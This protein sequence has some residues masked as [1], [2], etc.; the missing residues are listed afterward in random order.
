MP[1][2][3]TKKGILVPPDSSMPHQAQHRYPRVPLESK[4][5]PWG[6]EQTCTTGLSYYHLVLAVA[7]VPASG[8]GGPPIRGAWPNPGAVLLEALR[9]N[10][11]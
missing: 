1:Q 6:M 8:Q 9:D 7:A 11:K 3:K 2:K 10:T 5:G 4:M